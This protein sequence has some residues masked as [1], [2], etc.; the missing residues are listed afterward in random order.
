MWYESKLNKGMVV[1]SKQDKIVEYLTLGLIVLSVEPFIESLMKLPQALGNISYM[2]S[3]YEATGSQRRIISSIGSKLFNASAYFELLYPILLLYQFTKEKVNKWLV[4]G[5]VIVIVGY[6]LHEVLLGG[7]SKLVQNLLYTIVVFLIMR[8]YISRERSMKIVKYGV[9]VIAVGL[10]GMLAVT[11][12]RFVFSASSSHESVLAWLSLYAGEGSLNFNSY[13]WHVTKTTNGESTC[14]FL[15]NL[16]GYTDRIMVEDQWELTETL[17]IPGNIFYTYVGVFFKDYGKHL[18]VL[19]LGG[20][21]LITYFLVRFRKLIQLHQ[22]ILLCFCARI[23]CLPTFYTF[24]TFM[25]QVNL[26]VA[27]AFC[28]VLYA[29]KRGM[30]YIR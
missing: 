17:G 8:Y 18:T 2:G 4:F 9:W 29:N 13:M 25:A 1:Y 21:S 11:I 22:V 16:L 7:R 27:I 5:M 19:V 6:W 26:C 15:M 10:L 24:G 20:L 23:L 14:L 3:M 12:G 28:I 30:I